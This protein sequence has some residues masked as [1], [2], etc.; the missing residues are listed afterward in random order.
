MYFIKEFG[1][2][3]HK[4]NVFLSSTALHGWFEVG[5]MTVLLLSKF[6]EILLNHISFMLCHSLLQVL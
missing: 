5:C 1:K 3:V 2:M 4:S 6:G